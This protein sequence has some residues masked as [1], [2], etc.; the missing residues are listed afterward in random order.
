MSKNMPYMMCELA[1][2]S[3]ALKWH[4]EMKTGRQFK[5]TVCISDYFNANHGLI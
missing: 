5:I 3:F 1:N 4:V 2:H